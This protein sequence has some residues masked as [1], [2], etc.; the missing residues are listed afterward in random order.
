MKFDDQYSDEFLNAYI[1]GELGEQEKIQLFE[2]LRH[3]QILSTRVCKLQKT[4]DMVRLA[5]ENI[6]TPEHYQSKKQLTF[7]NNFGFGIA[8]SILLLVGATAGWLVHTQLAPENGLLQIAQSVQT[9][10]RSSSKIMLHVTTD[11]HLKLEAVLE[12]TERLL[13]SSST[14]HGKLQ[15]EVIANGKGLDFLRADT[16][17][18][19]QRIKAMQE[20]HDN[21]T[22]LACKLT[23]DRLKNR[24][25]LDTIPLLP[26]IKTVPTVLGEVIRRKQQGWAYVK[27]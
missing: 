8:A 23:M 3:N 13:Q 21:L 20:R 10:Q 17:H 19:A 15:V 25:G 9:G 1:D 14:N 7:K 24:A 2:D 22:F 5:Y 27:I 11:D 12:E 4:H 16:S 6:S 18:F 26:N